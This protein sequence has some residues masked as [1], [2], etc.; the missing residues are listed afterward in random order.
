MIG[1]KLSMKSA[2]FCS[3]MFLE[4]LIQQY[5]SIVFDFLTAGI[6]KFDT[7]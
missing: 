3:L 4:G 1:D 2:H 5:T 7:F 6:C